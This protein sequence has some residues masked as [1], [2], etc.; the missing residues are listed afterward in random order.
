MTTEVK[1]TKGLVEAVD[2]ALGVVSVGKQAKADGKVDLNDLGLLLQLVPLIGPAVQDLS[3]IPAELKDLSTDEAAALIA[4]VGGKLSLGSAHAEKV[5]TEALKLVAQAY[6]LF[7]AL[8][9][10][11]TV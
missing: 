7:Q 11:A 2:L 8:E 1:D 5:A 9:A 6:S 4:H 10:P 3:D